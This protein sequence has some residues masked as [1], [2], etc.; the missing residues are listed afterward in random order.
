MEARPSSAY[1]LIISQCGREAARFFKSDVTW[2]PQPI[3]DALQIENAITTSWGDGDTDPRSWDHND[4][5][6]YVYDNAGPLV[7]GSNDESN[8]EA[9]MTLNEEQAFV[10]ALAVWSEIA[11]FPDQQ[12]DIT[13]TNYAAGLQTVWV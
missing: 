4:L 8:S 1:R 7:D 12:N 2:A 6:C 3:Y 13:Y 10:Q 9:P 5:T 11:G